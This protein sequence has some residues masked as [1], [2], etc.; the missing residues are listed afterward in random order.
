[1]RKSLSSKISFVDDF[2]SNIF[3][4]FIYYHLQMHAQLLQIKSN[5]IKKQIVSKDQEKSPR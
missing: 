4:R 2:L 3:N 5:G 1:M